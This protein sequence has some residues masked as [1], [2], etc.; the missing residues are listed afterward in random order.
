MA[1]FA[2]ILVRLW[3]LR[4]V[5][6]LPEQQLTELESLLHGG[7]TE[8]AAGLLQCSIKRLICYPS[9]SS[10]LWPGSRRLQWQFL[11]CGHRSKKLAK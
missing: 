8:E 6:L 3:Q 4:R 9:R 10:L 1:A 2:L 5:V 7:R 11:N